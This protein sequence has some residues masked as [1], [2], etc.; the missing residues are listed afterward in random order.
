MNKNRLK[1]YNDSISIYL[2]HAD[3]IKFRN[4]AFKNKMTISE[5][6]RYLIML[7]IKYDENKKLNSKYLIK[8]N[9]LDNFFDDIGG[10]YN[11]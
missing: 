11:R 4:I 6:N 7:I 5:L 9:K 2:E 8:E 1:L 10:I 3:K